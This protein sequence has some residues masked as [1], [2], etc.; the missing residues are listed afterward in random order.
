MNVEKFSKI[1]ESL[2]QYRRA[3]LGDFEK[4]LNGKPVDLLYVDPLPSDSILI[5]VLSSNT[6]FVLGRKGTGK[7]TI[8]ARAQSIIREKKENISV[9]IDVKAIYDLLGSVESPVNLIKAEA[10]S[11][12]ILRAHLLRKFFLASVISELLKELRETLNKQS[13]I[14]R[15]FGKRNIK[16][17]IEKLAVIDQQVKVGK[18]SESEI[19]ILQLITNKAK[20][21]TKQ[22]ENSEGQV[23]TNVKLSES[24][25]S[26]GSDSSSSSF[27]ELLNDTELYSDYSDAVMR[28]FPFS[29][30]LREIKDLLAEIGMGRLI[31]FFDD[32]SEIT[33]LNQRLFVDVVLAPLNNS[34]DEKIKLKVAGYPG[35][36]YYGK[37][38]PGKVDTIYLDFPVLYKSQDVQTMENSAVDYTTRLLT[39]RFQEFGVNIE[40]YF[41]SSISISEHMR[42]IFQ[43]T[44]NIPRIMGYIL[45]YCLQDKVSQNQAITPVAIRL[46]A[47]KYYNYVLVKYF[48]RMNRFALEP[49]EKKLDRHIQ[50]ELLSTILNEVKEVRRRISTGEVGGTYFAGLSN[51]P[52]SHFSISPNF[53]SLLE[54]LEFNCL[55]TK[56]HEMR[57]KDGKDVSIYALFY[58]LCEAEKIPWGYPKGRRDDRSYFVQR[59]FSFNKVI[60]EFL[61]KKQTIRCNDCFATFPL[62]KKDFIAFYN[63][64]CPDCKRGTCSVINLSEEYPSDLKL[65]NDELMLEPVELDIL[66]VLNEENAGMRANEISAYI[67]VTYQLVGKRTGKM[68]ESGYIDKVISSGITLNKITKLAKDIYFS[69]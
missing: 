14:E 60:Y 45:Y 13:F 61:A 64:Q 5:T 38:D 41:D 63:W 59:C 36:V 24:G 28:S 9:Y 37:I 65:L 44:F 34:S 15:W 31:I 8:F 58:G 11:R 43:C 69:N 68:Q 32:F 17:V 53:E 49:F 2:R 46:A 10:I 21:R 35:R 12:D 56:Y 42:L 66:S 30:I 1:A 62:D 18:L 57:D 39:K 20:E 33:Y 40:E 52:A 6:T 47:Q 23:T 3:E 26:V 51:P 4:D 7:S 16:D 67:D 48:D 55:I 22:I 25:F 50:S 19:P 54:S 29:E 27:E